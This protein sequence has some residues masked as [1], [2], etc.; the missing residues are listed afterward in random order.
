PMR[1]GPASHGHPPTDRGNAILSTVPLSDPLAI[2]LPGERQRRVAVSTSIA[3]KVDGERVPVS[4]GSAHLD[5]LGASRTLW[6]FGAAQ[7]RA[8]QAKSLMQA[9]PSGVSIV[10]ADLN[11]WLGPSEPAARTLLGFFPSTPAGARQPTFAGGLAMDYMFFRLPP[12][13]RAHLERAPWTYGSDH[14]PLIG[15]AD[16]PQ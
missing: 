1:N 13:W 11:T 5:T 2:E 12:G 9:L 6:I 3:I 15:W 4:I 7:T 16:S 14:Y 10:G 8:A